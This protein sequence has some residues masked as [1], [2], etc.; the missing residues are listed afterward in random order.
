MFFF[1]GGGVLA[2]YIVMMLVII[3]AGAAVT[4]FVRRGELLENAPKWMNLLYLAPPLI[5][6]LFLI[7]G[8]QMAW[9]TDTRLLFISGPIIGV[10]SYLLA[11][12]LVVNIIKPVVI[13]RGI[14]EQAATGDG[15]AIT[16]GQPLGPADAAVNGDDDGKTGTDVSAV[17]PSADETGAGTATVRVDAAEPAA[18]TTGTTPES[19]PYAHGEETDGTD[20]TGKEPGHAATDAGTTEPAVDAVAGPADE[21]AGHVDGPADA[22]TEPPRGTHATTEDPHGT[23]YVDAIA[24][25]HAGTGSDGTDEKTDAA[26]P[27]VGHATTDGTTTDDVNH[28]AASTEPAS[29]ETAT[30]ATGTAAIPTVPPLPTAPAAHAENDAPR[31]PLGLSVPDITAPV[32]HLTPS[33]VPTATAPK[34]EPKDQ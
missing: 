9:A 13:M 28:E 10:A 29:G 24:P 5:S 18:D 4:F 22:D 27:P 11:L 12:L 7:T 19:G 15:P 26:T 31:P 6:F 3:A 8:P 1:V 33:P 30:G 34:T 21:P 20:A 25:A 16:D 23:A 14:D 17:E 32:M 2:A